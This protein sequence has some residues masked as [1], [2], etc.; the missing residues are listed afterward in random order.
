MLEV[1]NHQD[2]L[3]SR[4]SSPDVSMSTDSQTETL[5]L[6]DEINLVLQALRVSQD[7]ENKLAEE[8]L[9]AQKKTF[10][11]ICTNRGL[12]WQVTRQKPSQMLC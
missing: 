3:K 4:T 11:S 8:L 1:N 6:E 9:F 10:T 5:K 7:A 12:N 2:L